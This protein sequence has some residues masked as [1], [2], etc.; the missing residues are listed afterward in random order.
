MLHYEGVTLLEASGAGRTYRARLRLEPSSPLFGGHFPGQ[1][2]LPAIA[3]LGLALEGARKLEQRDLTLVG[4]RGVR[5]RRAVEP[6]A[7]IEL[8]VAQGIEAGALRFELRCAET[9][10]SSGTL[11]LRADARG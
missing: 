7:A 11:V 6:G 9:L 2:I 5:F 3:H 10:A 1:P 8:V 4:V